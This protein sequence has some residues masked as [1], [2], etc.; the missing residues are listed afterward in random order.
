MAAPQRASGTLAL[1]AIGVTTCIVLKAFTWRPGLVAFRA[2]NKSTETSNVLILAHGRS[3][4]SFLGQ[5]FNSNPEVFYIYEPLITFQVTTIRDS[6]LYEQSAKRLLDDLFNCRFGKQTE[7]LAFM[8]NMPLNRFS[9]HALTTPYCKNTTRAKDNRTFV[10]CKDLDPLITSLS[11]TLH[12]HVVVKVLIHRLLPFLEEGYLATLFKSSGNMKIIHLTR[13]PRA[14]V[15]SLDRVGWTF[16]K[17]VVNAASTNFSL[18]S[19]LTQRFC[20]EMVQSLSFALS[21]EAKFRSRF[22]IVRYEDLVTTPLKVSKELFDFSGI[23]MS[24]K[25][26]EYLTNSTRTNDRRNTY[27]YATVRNN[28]SKL[29]DSW[30]RQLNVKAVRAIESHCW[31]VMKILQYTP[32][33]SPSLLRN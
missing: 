15:A 1:F 12:K 26:E 32:L 25:V 24:A 23:P 5:I 4:S 28:V 33:Y 6:K 31:P 3:G 20:S 7:F 16:N 13:D 30:R 17:S 8:S 2:S 9:S 11:C 29:I 10:H 18:F 22:K 27:E 14:V 21:A 19:T